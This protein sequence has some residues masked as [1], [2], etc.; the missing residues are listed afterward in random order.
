ML[1]NFKYQIVEYFSFV[2]ITM[3]RAPSMIGKDNG[4]TAWLRKK[5][6][7]PSIIRDHP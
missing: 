1:F 5:L 7:K 6:Q 2:S 4:M 3:I